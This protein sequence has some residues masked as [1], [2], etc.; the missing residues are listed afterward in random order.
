ML[1]TIWSVSF[2]TFSTFFFALSAVIAG[3]FNPYSNLSNG[4]VRSWAKSILWAS[5]IKVEV[6]GRDQLDLRHPVIYMANHL[7]TFDILAM[8]VA[9]PGTV[10]FIAKK[11]LFRIPFLAQGM[12]RVGMISIDRGNSQ[13]AKKSLADAAEK[14]KKGVSVIIFPE[15]T[16]S[17]DGKIQRFKKGGFI[18][19]IKGKF[20]IVPT[21]IR[22]SFGIM[23][24]K[25]LKVGKG[26][27]EVEFLQPV[28]AEKYS[29]TQRNDL[30]Q[31]VYRQIV[32]KLDQQSAGENPDEG[33]I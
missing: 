3:L 31:E 11:E 27:I 6:I 13:Q 17:R 4:I 21:A 9:I 12:R 22:G 2:A 18:L 25:S 29:Y 14:M 28:A 30:L 19:A 7:S 32:N 8:A 16:R 5:G 26:R 1:R 23:R 33:T 10:R 20:P 24:K 15:G